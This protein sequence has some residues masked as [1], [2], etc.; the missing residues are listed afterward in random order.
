MSDK[1]ARK[2]GSIQR[3]EIDAFC[4]ASIFCPFCGQQVVENEEEVVDTKP[5]KHTLFIAHDEGFEYRSKTFDEHLGISGVDDDE[6]SGMVGDDVPGIDGV[7]DLVDIPDSIKFASYV[8]APS[9]FGSYCGFAAVD[10]DL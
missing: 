6:V 7:T 2:K 10:D 4:Y 9:F 5:C 8:P 3:V 1:T